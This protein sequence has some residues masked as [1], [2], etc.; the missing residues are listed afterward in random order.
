MLLL[1]PPAG[2]QHAQAREGAPPG[3]RIGSH[4]DLGLPASSTVRRSILS[5]KSPRLWYLAVAAQA[6]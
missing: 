6:S 5:L 2:T 1:P 4:L 3:T